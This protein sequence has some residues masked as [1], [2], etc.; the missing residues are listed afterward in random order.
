MKK[1]KVPPVVAAVV[2]STCLSARFTSAEPALTI[3]NRNF[4]VVRDTIPLNLQRGVN[5]VRVSD[6]T[7]GL[8]PDSVVLRDP[9]GKRALQIL[10]Q[11]YRADPVTQQR[12]LALYEGKTIDFLVPGASGNSETIRGK[13][14]RSGYVPAVPGSSSY[15]GYDGGGGV[16]QPLV[17]VDGKLRFQLPGLPLF[18]DIGDDTILKPMLQ[19]TLQSEQPG[20]LQAELAYI[21]RGMSW[22]ADYNIV[23]PENGDLLELVAWVT[24]NNRSGKTFNNARIKLMAGDISKIQ[25]DSSYDRLGRFFANSNATAANVYT[26]P[27]TE[28]TFDEYHLYTLTRPS[29]VRDGET[30]QVEFTRAQRI[31]SQRLYI[32]DGAYIDPNRYRNWSTE[33]IRNDRDYGTQSNP[34]VWV[35]REFINS[36]ANGLG[37]PLPQGRMRFYRRDADGQVEFTGENLIDHTPQGETM[38]IYTGNAFDI[39]GERRR[40]AYKVDMNQ[41]GIADETFEIKLRN[42]KKEAVEVRVVEHLYRWTNWEIPSKSSEFQKMD[43]QTIEF[44]LPLK[45]NEEKVLTYT[46]RYTWS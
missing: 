26:P 9:S 3:Y 18:P 2:A 14:I 28:K 29:T 21:T 35:M 1:S 10:E 19:W 8:E 22:Q 7:S 42:R 43:A 32:Y 12:L 17:E 15:G 27:V 39:V 41:G 20:P 11:N 31:K 40:T 5:Q 24:L 36:T 6:V 45:P 44:R 38:R 16:G 13:I 46:V 37:I 34:K 4:A 30:K 25:Q 23:A 33:N